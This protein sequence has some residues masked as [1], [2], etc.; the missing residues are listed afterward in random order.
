MENENQKG[1]SLKTIIVVVL[2]IS[3]II[4]FLVNK[5]NDEK[6]D[7]SDKT[8]FND[9][10]NINS[11]DDSSDNVKEDSKTGIKLA[12]E[13]FADN[14]EEYNELKKLQGKISYMSN[15]GTE[16]LI[17]VKNKLYGISYNSLEEYIEFSEMPDSV[18]TFNNSDIGKNILSYKNGKISCYDFDNFKP[19]FE[20]IDF[21]ID[22]DFIKVKSTSVMVLAKVNDN[23]MVRYYSEN[24]E[25]NLMELDSEEPLN[26]I[27]RAYEEEIDVKNTV[28]LKDA[29]YGMS[30]YFITN[31]NEVYKIRDYVISGDTIETATSKPIITNVDTIFQ[32]DEVNY[33]LTVPLYSK[34]GDENAIYS[35]VRGANSFDESDDLDI[36]FNMP[37]GHKPS[38]IKEIFRHDDKIVFV[39]ENEE[40]FITDEIEKEGKSI[41]EMTQ[42]DNI[43]EFG[44]DGKIV[45]MASKANFHDLY[46][47]KDNG[48]LYYT[49][50][51]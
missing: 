5:G 34:I 50:M 15:I 43:S 32:T 48:K 45:N 6:L 28:I 2:I 24:D 3:A 51:E 9:S 17:L 20:D 30:A 49:Y 12:E 22:T 40:V 11:S 31:D 46:I 36:S 8:N 38:E 27:L 10:T 33:N 1:I 41:Y 35:K 4:I 18:W 23:Y 42:L 19:R 21:N 29:S 14:Q 16:P 37:E 39:F 47:L 44:D 26:T 13:N 7:T 25:T